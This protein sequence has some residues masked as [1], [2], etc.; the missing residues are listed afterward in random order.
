MPNSNTEQRKLAA[1]IFTDIAGYSTLDPCPLGRR[2]LAHRHDLLFGKV[3][4]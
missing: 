4:S 2:V 3:R 1:I